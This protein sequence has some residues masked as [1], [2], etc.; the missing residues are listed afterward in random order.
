MLELRAEL[1]AAG[2]AATLV[3][4]SGASVFGLFP[5]L[6]EAAAARERLPP[7]AWSVTATLC[8]S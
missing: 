7:A 2:A 4:G 5:S 6:A 3:A 1:V 8:A